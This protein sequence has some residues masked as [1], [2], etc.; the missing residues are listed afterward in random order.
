M[1]DEYTQAYRSPQSQPEQPAPAGKPAATVARHRAGGHPLAVRAWTWIGEPADKF[2]VGLLIAPLVVLVGLLLWWL[3]ASR[4]RWSDR[5]LVV[6]D[7]HGCDR[8]YDVLC[9]P[10]LSRYGVAVLRLARRGQRV[11]G[12][13]V[14]LLGAC[15]GRSA[16]Q[17]YC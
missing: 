14:A 6:R 8:G 11:A 15:L 3:L 12:M 13:A 5:W 4:L 17:A 10:E 7:L 16:G 1:S 2:F 9:R